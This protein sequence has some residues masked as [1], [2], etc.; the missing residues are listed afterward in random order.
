MAAWQQRLGPLLEAGA[1]EPPPDRLWATIHGRVF[2]SAGNVTVRGDEGDWQPVS[3]G[4]TIKLLHVDRAAGTRSFLMRFAA[5]GELAGHAH[6]VDEECLM[7]EG[8][9]AF[10]D[11]VL[12]AGDYHLA[13]A[14]I[15]HAAA[16]STRGALIFIRASL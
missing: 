16:R 13:R 1:A 14:G 5:G 9:V 10:G 11:L 3:P 15:Y 8:E 2:G 4:V 7:L 6:P 12:K